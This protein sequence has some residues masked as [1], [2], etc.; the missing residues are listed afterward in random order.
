MRQFI[1]NTTPYLYAGMAGAAIACAYSLVGAVA[2]HLLA[3][4]FLI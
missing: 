3:E 2:I 4:V 1:V